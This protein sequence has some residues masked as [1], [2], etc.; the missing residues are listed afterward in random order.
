MVRRYGAKLDATRNPTSPLVLAGEGFTVSGSVTLCDISGNCATFRSP[1]FMIDK[2]PPTVTM[3]VSP[4]ILWPPDH[5]NVAVTIKVTVNDNLALPLQPIASLTAASSEPDLAPET[6]NFP[7][8]VNGHDS[9]SRPVV[10]TPGAFAFDTGS[11]KSGNSTTTILLR[12]ER[13]GSGPGRVYTI[14]GTV[15]DAAGN[16]TPFTRTVTVPHDQ[17]S[18][19]PQP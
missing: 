4:D 13:A 8:D 3:S 1:N 18:A 6:G 9:S 10:L 15:L 14:A 12:A 19:K 17:S 5:G 16:P 7:G 2:T 11:I